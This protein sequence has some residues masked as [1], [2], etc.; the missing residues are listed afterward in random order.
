LIEPDVPIFGHKRRSVGVF[1][2]TLFGLV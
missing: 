2:A 1:A